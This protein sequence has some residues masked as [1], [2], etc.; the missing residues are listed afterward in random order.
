M[1]TWGG[2]NNDNTFVFGDDAR[3]TGSINGGNLNQTNTL[4]YQAYSQ[5]LL[6]SLDSTNAGLV[7]TYGNTLVNGFENINYLI[8]NSNQENR[9]N[10]PNK[11][12][13]TLVVT[14]AFTGY[15]NDPI[16]FA[17]YNVLASLSGQDQLQF[18]VPAFVSV[19]DNVITAV[20]NGQTMFFLNFIHQP[21]PPVPPTPPTPV[22]PDVFNPLVNVGDIN[23]QPFF[24]YEAWPYIDNA[25]DSAVDRNI[26]DI[27]QGIIAND[28]DY[29]EVLVKECL[30]EEKSP[31][32][33][34]IEAVKPSTIQTSAR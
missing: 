34:R 7:Q 6:V 31:Q 26:Y 17:G 33:L 32:C 14:D 3:I 10:L 12:G 24:N 9:I 27:V 21:E 5:S 23:Y 2:G 13:N 18:D 25:L 30:D 1:P 16:F 4:D 22:V 29:G 11:D 19:N 20:I 28:K 8:T 15:I